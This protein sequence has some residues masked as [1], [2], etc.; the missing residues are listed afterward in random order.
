VNKG[1]RCFMCMSESFNSEHCPHCGNYND[2]TPESSLHL[3]PGTILENKY[4]IGK[5]LG[6]GGFGI[7][8]LAWDQKLNLKQAIKEYLPVEFAYRIPGTPEVS[9]YKKD[10][11]THFNYGVEKFLEEART[12]A[13][14]AGHPN[15]VWIRDYFEANGTAYIVMEHIEGMTIKDYVKNENGPLSYRE[16]F[17]IF[18]P[19][20]DVLREV[21]T[22]GVLHRDISPDNMLIDKRGRIVLIDFG[23][24]R[25]AIGEKS[26]STSVIMKPGYSPE[27]QY[28][29]KGRQGPW[30]D[31]YAVA[32][33]FYFV[34]TG[35]TPPE[36]LDRLSEEA[37]V[38]PSK[39]GISIPPAF[40]K[41]LLKALAVKIDDRYQNVEDF[42][43]KLAQSLPFSEEQTLDIEKPF[44]TII[45]KRSFTLAIALAAIVIIAFSA[46][47]L[48][49]GTGSPEI[50]P[51]S[52]LEVSAAGN[53]PGNIVN[54]G[55]AASQ[56]DWIYY[57]SNDG[58]KIYRVN[59]DGTM[60]EKV[61]DDDSW[62]I[63]IANDWVYYRTWDGG[64]KI[65]RIRTDGSN[66]EMISA[67]NAW[68]ISV[69]DDWIYYRDQDDNDK[70]YRISLDGKRQD[71]ISD[72]WAG[73]KNILGNWIFY[74]NRNDDNT[75]Y[76]TKIDGTENQ[77]INNTNADWLVTSDSWLYFRNLEDEGKI[78]RIRNDG[79]EKK[80]ISDNQAIYLNTYDGWLY[81]SNLSDNSKIYRIRTDGKDEQKINE[82]SSSFLNIVNGWI[83]YRNW[84]DGGKVYK[85]KTDGSNRRIVE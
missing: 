83:Y 38:P 27:E 51:T 71:L 17:N 16:A 53:T 18:S 69:V 74:I 19:V 24:A 26:Q 47:F 63:N 67:A 78:Y 29:R 42:Q 30:T 54:G 33:S 41:T 80:K 5:A 14:F 28:Q 39:M 81:Y 56:G 6:Q 73:W 43:K 76:R 23:S 35:S 66:R 22:D 36:S 68:Y 50:I 60:L 46:F 21:H 45:K 59:H 2:P 40:E 75:I 20:L 8:Y 77:K 84:S 31:I 34:I 13:R 85:I 32:A 79:G 70:T 65:Y 82:D 64:R 55:L 52:E 57:R 4:L 72:Q 10:L 15:I 12:L 48:V 9:I 44:L 37:L 11:I 7:T 61:N 62:Y 1:N 49:Q 25:Q 3:P 58:G